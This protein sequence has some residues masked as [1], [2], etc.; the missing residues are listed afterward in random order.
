MILPVNNT[1]TAIVYGMKVGV[2]YAMTDA[3][4]NSESVIAPGTTACQT[5]LNS[6]ATISLRSADRCPTYK[7]ISSSVSVDRTVC[8]AQ[9]YQ[10]EFTQTL[11]TAGAPVTVLGGLYSAVLFLN[12]VPGIAAGRTYNVRVRA[13]HSSG[14]FG[15]WGTT[16]CLR[17]S[18][19]GMAMLDTEEAV[20]ALLNQTENDFAIYPNPSAN[21]QFT[22]VWKTSSERDLNMKVWDLSGKLVAAQ[23]ENMNGQIWE[24]KP[25]DLANGIYVVEVNGQRQRWVITQ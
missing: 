7:A 16:Q 1:G 12:N 20:A 21:G 9:R 24:S 18:G 5:T 17:T 2:V 15:E 23:S 6:E 4:G 10:W 14:L 19:T 3:A 25:L 22:L 13:Q 8:G 11:P